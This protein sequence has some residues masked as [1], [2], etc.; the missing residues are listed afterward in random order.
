M[1]IN[2]TDCVSPRRPG[3]VVVDESHVVRPAVDEDGRH[4]LQVE[5]EV[6]PVRVGCADVVDAGGLVEAGLQLA[7]AVAGD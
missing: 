1:Q 4:L 5:P 3:L 6:E 2:I 7:A